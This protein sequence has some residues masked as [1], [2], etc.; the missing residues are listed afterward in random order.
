MISRTRFALPAAGALILALLVPSLARAQPAK[1]TGKLS[2]PGYTVIAM[3]AGG[4]AKTDRARRGKFKLRPTTKKVTLQLRA[5]D[6][7]YAGPVVVAKAKHGKEAIV[8]V[9]AGARLG[10]VNLR[11]GDGYAKLAEPLPG[12]YLDVKRTARAEQ[13]AP[14]GAGNLGLVPAS[15]GGGA[16]GDGDLDGIPDALDVDDDGDVILDRFDPERELARAPGDAS[17]VVVRAISLLNLDLPDA[18][19][20]NA[21]GLSEDQIEA[22]LPSFGG[23]ILGSLGIE[24]EGQSD[25][26]VELDC[27]DPDTGL[28][29]CRKNGSTG[30]ITSF[31][32]LP[33]GSSLG[34]RFPGCCDRDE[35]GFGSLGWVT[36]PVEGV[37][38]HAVPLLHG[39]TSDQVGAGDLLIARA[40]RD[41]GN[42]AFTG[43]LSSIFETVPALVS[44]TDEA[45]SSI[46]MSYPVTPGA[47]GTQENPFVPTDGPDADTDVEV[48]LTFWRPQR[49]ALPD[50]PGKWID[51]G[52]NVYVA[53]RR[54]T[55]EPPAS[56][57]GSCQSSAYSETDPNL[58]PAQAPDFPL[59]YETVS[60]LADSADDQP[61]D[62]ANTF[63]FTLNL[64]R[65][66]GNPPVE[67]STQGLFLRA[68]PANPLAGPPDNARA[69]V[70]WFKPG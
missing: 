23:L 7:T 64:N 41:D 24:A 14:L 58:T 52:H 12:K 65:C 50:E 63:T 61:A 22:A 70:A 35:D 13:G 69:T 15:T 25:P 39:A 59:F 49:R 43:I 10:K 28:I 44:Y 46:G 34:D 11:S 3:A 5:P 8:G 67:Y 60:G 54:G 6:A 62:P 18:V 20:A 68:Q 9:R 47:P 2:K 51:V 17:D 42:E 16:P 29:Y 36:I 57:G 30:T 48:T 55:L 38:A 19:N 32:V 37:D 26:P 45:G 21:P 53:E 27:G 56:Q 31:P 4:K 33:P 1:I 40:T 66:F